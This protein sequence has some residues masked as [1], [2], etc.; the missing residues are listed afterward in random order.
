[1]KNGNLSFES[2][3]EFFLCDRKAIKHT[4]STNSFAWEKLTYLDI[5]TYLTEGISNA[6]ALK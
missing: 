1:M 4:A 5:C 6:Q 3:C 2:F